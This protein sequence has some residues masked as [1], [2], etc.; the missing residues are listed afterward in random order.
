MVTL[1]CITASPCIL[2]SASIVNSYTSSDLSY[3][4]G[5]SVS[6]ITYRPGVAKRQVN[7]PSA[8][9]TASVIVPA[10]D[11]FI[12]LPVFSGSWSQTRFSPFPILNLA[13]IR[14]RPLSPSSFVT[15]NSSSL[16][17]TSYAPLMT[18]L[19][20][21]VK[22]NMPGFNAYPSG[23]FVSRKVYVPLSGLRMRN[24]PVLSLT[25]VPITRPVWS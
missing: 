20:L 24:V 10:T 13:P 21:T 9:V 25:E 2:P 12:P 8:P 6:R 22:L 23:A 1:P 16:S 17:T 5:A 14:G 19:P 3:P 18:S 7:V 15:V 4:K 11:P